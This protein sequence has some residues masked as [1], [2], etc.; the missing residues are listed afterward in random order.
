MFISREIGFSRQQRI[1]QRDLWQI[2]GGGVGKEARDR[3][4][5]D[6]LLSAELARLRDIAEVVDPG[7]SRRVEL[8]QNGPGDRLVTSYWG[9]EFIGGQ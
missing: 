2:A 4:E 9:R 8:V 1:D 5:V 3:L 6:R 7:N